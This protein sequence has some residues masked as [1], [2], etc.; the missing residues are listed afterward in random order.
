MWRITRFHLLHLLL[1]T[2]LL[3]FIGCGQIGS[4]TPRKVPGADWKPDQF[5]PREY[6]PLPPMSLLEADLE[7]WV[8]SNS[9]QVSRI[10]EAQFADPSGQGPIKVEYA[11]MS[12]PLG[13]PWWTFAT[14]RYHDPTI[15]TYIISWRNLGRHQPDFLKLDKTPRT[16]WLVP[17][18]S[19]NQFE[20]RDGIPLL[21]VIGIEGVT[22]FCAY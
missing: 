5:L 14:Y 20:F 8:A 7:Q 22:K 9:N 12:S 1:A 19:L 10:Y 3:L 13:N 16:H 4:P 17:G 21:E 15:G 6:R 2:N 11:R 18:L